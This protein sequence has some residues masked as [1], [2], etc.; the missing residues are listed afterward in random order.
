M[1]LREFNRTNLKNAIECSSNYRPVIFC[2]T[3]MTA[4]GMLLMVAGTVVILIDHVELG[5]PQYDREYERYVGSSLAHII[6]EYDI[7]S[8]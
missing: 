1:S 2:S 3:S 6:G 8:L 7:V 5:P 4:I